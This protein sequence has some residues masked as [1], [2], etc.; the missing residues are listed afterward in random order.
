M[1]RRA[2]SGQD[3]NHRPQIAPFIR[4]KFFLED[5][6]GRGI[7]RD[8]DGF[9]NPFIARISA[10]GDISVFESAGNRFNPPKRI[11]V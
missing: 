9:A 2:R 3:H 4:P 5:H 10:G 6:L 1:G 7:E 11:R 8:E